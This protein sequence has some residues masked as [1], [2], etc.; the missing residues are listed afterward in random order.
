MEYSLVVTLIIV[1]IFIVFVTTFLLLRGRIPE[2]YSLVWYLFSIL[3]LLVAI[4]PNIFVD[5]SKI[6]GFEVMS[7]LVIAI[8]IGL[9]LLLNMVL[10]VMIAGQKKKSI[11]LIQELSL[12]KKQM[13]DIKKWNIC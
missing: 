10:T 1:S 12:L 13:E 7:N 11:L 6:L 5:I 2:K 4:L 9:L 8:V 3:I